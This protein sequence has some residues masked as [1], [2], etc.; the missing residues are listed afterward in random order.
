[1]GELVA[2]RR[3]LAHKDEEISQLAKILQKL[4]KAQARQT[5]DRRWEPPRTSRHSMH[6]GNCTDQVVES[7]DVAASDNIGVLNGTPG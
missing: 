6:Y 1:M 3:S 5:Q 4:E 7:D 2:T